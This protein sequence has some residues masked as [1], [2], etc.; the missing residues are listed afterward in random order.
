MNHVKL[1][2]GSEILTL[3]VKDILEQNNIEYIE[4]NDVK[5]SIAVGIGT[6]DKAV[7][8]FVDPKDLEYAKH[9][10]EKNDIYE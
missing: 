2:V 6:A 3:A 9:L 5:S 8:I 1:F 4:R 7:H 10:L